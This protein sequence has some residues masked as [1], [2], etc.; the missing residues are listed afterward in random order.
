MYGVT[1]IR[2]VCVGVLFWTGKRGIFFMFPLAC[3]AKEKREQDDRIRRGHENKL[4]PR[5]AT[6]EFCLFF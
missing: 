1:V 4:M 2:E 3:G 5:V 6:S